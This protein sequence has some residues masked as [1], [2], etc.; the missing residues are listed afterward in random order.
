MNKG[1]SLAAS[2]TILLSVFF[3]SNCATIT[4]RTT[5]RIPVTSAPKG[6]T[7]SVNGSEKGVTPLEVK[8]VRKKKDQVIRIESPGYNPV[9]IRL[10]SKMSGG[11][12][13]GNFL[14]GLIPATAVTLAIA[15]GQMEA[16]D[17]ELDHV[18]GIYGIWGGCILAFTGLF[19]L[20][21]SAGDG[22]ELTP[23][24][25]IVNLQ[26]AEGPPR[27]DTILIDAEDFRNV[28]W[29]RVRRD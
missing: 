29:I 27:V 16:A 11:V 28:T 10:Q 2:L 5:Q 26:K 14:L 19:T 4:R 13:I 15:E 12:Y 7:V 22:Y 17:D 1:P 21:D 23:K 6:A 25:L 18:T 8:L 3:A 24:Q 9:E 20:M